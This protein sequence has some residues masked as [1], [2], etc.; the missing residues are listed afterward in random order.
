MATAKLTLSRIS[1]GTNMK[2]TIA[3]IPLQNGKLAVV[4]G[5]NSGIGWYTALEL[6]RAGSQVVLTARSEAKGTEAVNRIRHQIPTAN[7]RAEILDLASLASVRAFAAKIADESKLDLLVNNAGV[8]QIPKR[9][10]SEDGSE[11]Q[12]AT[13]FLGHFA[14]TGLLLAA[15]LRARSPRVTTVSSIA[16]G[17]GLK[18]INFDDL[19]WERS[20]SPWKAYCQSKLADLMFTLEL[21]RRCAAT[22]IPLLS[23]AAHPGIAQTNLQRSGPGKPPTGPRKLVH[24]LISQ[25]AFRGA[26]PTLRAATEIS[27]NPG[28]YYGPSGVFQFKGNPVLISIPKPARDQAAAR[29]LWEI[30]ESLTGV[31][32]PG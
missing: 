3:D 26:L 11:R 5:A 20:Y 22:G 25:D 31:K 30:A 9:E 12:F 19:Q 23:N 21:S 16:A 17:M 28:G 10:L 15:L 1:E 14:L 7:I 2:W 6:A 27:A 32:Y 4:T 18:W 8:M 29:R 13:N 24:K